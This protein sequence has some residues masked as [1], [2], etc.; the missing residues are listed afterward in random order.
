M[1]SIPVEKTV[2]LTAW[3]GHVFFLKTT[4]LPQGRTRR[5]YLGNC[6]T[7]T[8]QGA[9]LIFPA[10]MRLFQVFVE[11]LDVFRD[12]SHVPLLADALDKTSF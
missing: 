10:F 9:L 1:D 3:S 8:V 12:V 2:K 5:S 6:R 11:P 7:S 4:A